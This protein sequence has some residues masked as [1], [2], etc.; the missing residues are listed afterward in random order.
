MKITELAPI[1]VGKEIRVS[2]PGHVREAQGTLESVSFQW[3]DDPEAW[4]G[5]LKVRVAQLQ[6]SDWKIE[7]GPYA[8][9]DLIPQSTGPGP[10][11]CGLAGSGE[12]D[13]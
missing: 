4:G 2:E 7:V 12:D 13:E 9:V 8:T 1:H 3:E 11:A 5:G 6:I 10:D